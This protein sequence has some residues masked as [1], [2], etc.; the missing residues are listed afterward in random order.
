MPLPRQIATALIAVGLLLLAIS[1]Y[2]YGLAAQSGVVLTV[3]P[4]LFAGLLLGRPGLWLTTAVLL[5]IFALGCWSDLHA[6]IVAATTQDILASLLQPA[7]GCAIVALILDRLIR[8]SD[9]ARRRNRDLALLC[10]QLEIEM[11]QKEQS[12]AQLIHSQRM[13]SLGKLA[14]SAAHDFNNV[15]S[16]ILGYAT[17]HDSAIASEDA[18]RVRLEKIIAATRRGKRLTNKLLT[19]ARSDQPLRE[20]FDANTALLG[21]APM[22]HSM[23]G[24]RIDVRTAPCDGS[25]WIRMDHAEF[26]ACVLNIAKNACDAM[27]DGGTFHIESGVLGDEVCLRFADTGHG[28]PADVAARAFEPFFTTKPRTQGTGIGLAVVF[29]TIIE[30]GGHVELDS[31]PGNGACFTLRLPRQPA[32]ARDADAMRAVRA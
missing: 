24:T 16:I 13:D 2:R 29:R 30:A 9:F 28:M 8:Q 21:L 31:S 18:M 19:L 15:L 25:A 7:M 26:E 11:R 14:S 22:I 12:Q 6:G 23:A 17:L 20:T 27:P 3:V 10:R 5:A 4:L 1:H 32:P